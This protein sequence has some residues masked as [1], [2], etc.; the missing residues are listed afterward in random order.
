[1]TLA[2]F[3]ASG[4]AGARGSLAFDQLRYPVS[5]SS[6]LYG[7]DEQ[8]LDQTQLTSLTSFEVRQRLWGIF[9][10]F[11]PLS[12]TEDISAAINQRIAEAGGE[13]VTNLSVQ[14]E[15]CGMNYVPF[16]N[17]LPIYPAC[18]LVTV[19]GNVIKLAD[20]ASAADVPLAAADVRAAVRQGL[21]A[22]AAKQSFRPL[23][24]R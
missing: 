10:S 16:V 17:W 20:S 23:A 7:P 15:N 9:W 18:T 14:V 19:T 24:S 13:G 4:C 12:G 21:A 8:V 22:E 2:A 3:A 1:M 6:Y 5:S 11:I